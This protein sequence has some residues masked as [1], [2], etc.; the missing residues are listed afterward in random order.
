MTGKKVVELCKYVPYIN[1]NL[2]KPQR[3]KI[4]GEVAQ[5]KTLNL[6][7]VYLICNGRT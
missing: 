2:H 3:V 4:N 6:H 7:E 1:P 5:T